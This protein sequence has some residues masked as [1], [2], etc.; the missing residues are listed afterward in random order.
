LILVILAM[1][2][3]L[4]TF[5]NLV[6][7]VTETR[8]I[9]G[10]VAVAGT[11]DT[12]ETIATAGVSKLGGKAISE[13]TFFD[14]ASLTKV[15]STLPA[16]LKLV[17]GGEIRFDDKIGRFFSNAGWFQTP[18]IADVTVAQLLTHSS[19][20]PAWRPI[21]A[22]VSS[23]QTA[24]ANVLQSSLGHPPGSY[25]YSDLGFIL[26][27]ALIER[28]SGLR[29]DVF[30][31]EQ[32]FGPM[33][34]G[35]LQYGPISDV[36]IAATEDCGWRNVLLE[37]VVHD[38][39]AHV[40]DGVA[41]HAGLFG[42]AADIAR[43]AQMYLQQDARLGAPALLDLARRE[44]VTTSDTRRGLGWQLKS[45]TSC[46]GE[47]AS[48]SSFGHTGFTGTS[49]WLDP[50]QGWFAVLL[51]NRVHPS[52]TKGIHLHRLRCTFHDAIATEIGG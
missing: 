42:T 8:D 14:L 49:L 15:L 22:T 34:L 41:G 30:V 12:V 44:Q 51:S 47:Y 43:F 3:P 25:V 19:G 18:S 5:L 46:A 16:I 21:F 48:R 36:P 17:D 23:R 27:G 45:A 11:A 38:E 26:L 28:V 50:E 40:M 35:T 33:G 1:H 39:N 31:R 6:S 52:R 9:P 2:D 24:L 4:T 13:D 32:L 29:Q 20:L 7:T 37:G 10:I